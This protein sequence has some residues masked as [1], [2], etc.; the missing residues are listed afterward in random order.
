MDFFEIS[1]S[2]RK[3]GKDKYVIGKQSSNPLVLVDGKSLKTDIGIFKNISSDKSEIKEEHIGL[4]NTDNLILKTGIFDNLS[5]AEL[6]SFKSHLEESY[7]SN[8]YL[9][10]GSFEKLSGNI[11][12]IGTGFSEKIFIENEKRIIK[13]VMMFFMRCV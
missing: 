13:D 7:V 8:L 4:S 9:N 1:Q 3:V 5:G 6:T 12:Q 10:T 2:I 11:I